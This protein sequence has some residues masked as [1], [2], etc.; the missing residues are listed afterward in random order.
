MPRHQTK[1]QVKENKKIPSDLGLKGFF[2]FLI[3]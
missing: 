1:E 2:W 3:L